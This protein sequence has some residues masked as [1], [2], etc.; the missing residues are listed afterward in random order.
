MHAV[1]CTQQK[2]KNKEMETATA[3]TAEKPDGWRESC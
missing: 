3:S 1:Q 2:Q